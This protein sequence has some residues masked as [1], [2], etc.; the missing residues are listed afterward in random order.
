MPKFPPE[1]LSAFLAF[2]AVRDWRHTRRPRSR[3]R[4]DRHAVDLDDVIAAPGDEPGRA[5]EVEADI[6]RLAVQAVE[7]VDRPTLTDGDV[8]P[9][10][11][12]SGARRRR[13]RAT[14]PDSRRLSGQVVEPKFGKRPIFRHARLLTHCQKCQNSHQN[15]FRHFWHFWQSGIGDT[16]GFSG[17]PYRR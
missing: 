8:M 7:L 2:L 13:S 12:Q 15:A 3:F 11:R 16:P 5:H 10:Y 17:W 6:R 14:A 1:R 9:P 4:G